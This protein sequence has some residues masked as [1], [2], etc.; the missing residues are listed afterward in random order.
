MSR[1]PYSQEY[2]IS[3]F[4]AFPP[5]NQGR[6]GVTETVPETV[7]DTVR[8]GDEDLYEIAPRRSVTVLH[9]R[10]R[11]FYD[12]LNEPRLALRGHILL[13]ES[14]PG[15]RKGPQNVQPTAPLEIL[16]AL[17][18]STPTFSRARSTSNWFRTQR[19]R[20]RTSTIPTAD[21]SVCGEDHAARSSTRT[22]ITSTG[23]PIS[24]SFTRKI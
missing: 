20:E 2:L 18:L 1:Q 4:H 11:L 22:R 3:R 14:S 13:E 5:P 15:L 24:R 12:V 17:P 23:L 16:L 19:R 6:P 9:M 8:P 10:V 21:T 7:S